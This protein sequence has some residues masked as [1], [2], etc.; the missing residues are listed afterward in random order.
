MPAPVDP[1]QLVRTLQVEL[2][3]GRALIAEAS[4]LEE[5]ERAESTLLGRKSPFSQVQ[6]SLGQL[7]A[8]DRRRVGL[9][10]NEVREALQ[11]AL[12]R[13]REALRAERA[14]AYLEADRIDVTLPGRRPRPGSLHP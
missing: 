8:A 9:R 5:L 6:R 14:R 3:R 2:D 7:S 10:T 1:E 11:E 12:G 13:R 4:G